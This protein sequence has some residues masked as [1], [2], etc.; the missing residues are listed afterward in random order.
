MKAK[1]TLQKQSK[2][3]VGCILITRFNFDIGLCANWIAASPSHS[4]EEKIR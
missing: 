4:L 3:K 2:L 1:M